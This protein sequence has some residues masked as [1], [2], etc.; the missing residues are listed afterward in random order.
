MKLAIFDIDGTLVQSCG[1]DDE[2]Y[3]RALD[4]VFGIRDV[5]TDWGSY[6]HSTDNAILAQL[7]RERL[8]R[9]MIDDDVHAMQERFVAHLAAVALADPGRFAM[10]P[11]ADRFLETLTRK[12]W[13]VAIATGGWRRSATFKLEQAGLARLHLPAAHADDH[14]L[15]E[16]IIETATRRAMGDTS[17]RAETTVYVGDGAWDVRAARNLGLGFV[18]IGTGA[19]AE[20]LRSVGAEWVYEDFQNVEELMAA[21]EA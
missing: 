18:G 3:L 19:R 1:A 12:G 4:E 2:C 8:G 21:L 13:R 14:R 9:Q 15:R 10:T 7:I 16:G 6:D 20:R 11:G 17:V 5:S